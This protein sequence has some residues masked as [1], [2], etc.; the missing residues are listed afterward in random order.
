MVAEA[1]QGYSG[2][3]D[4]DFSKYGLGNGLPGEPGRPR[5]GLTP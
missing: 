1:V 3:W 4:C 2:D 5:M